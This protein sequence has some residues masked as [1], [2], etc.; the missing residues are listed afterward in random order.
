MGHLILLHGYHE[1]LFIAKKFLNTG[2]GWA[3]ES[4]DTDTTKLLLATQVKLHGL[5]TAE[6]AFLCDFGD[7]DIHS[8]SFCCIQRKLPTQSDSSSCWRAG[9]QKKAGKKSRRQPHA[10]L[11][12]H[13]LCSLRS[14]SLITVSQS[15]PAAPSAPAPFQPLAGTAKNRNVHIIHLHFVS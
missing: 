10:R 11:R 13:F 12:C 5:L 14:I 9:G 4:Q 7:H 3:L 15:R 1:T 8:S 6:S 2:L